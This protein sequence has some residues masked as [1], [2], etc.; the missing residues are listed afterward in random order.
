MVQK[1]RLPAVQSSSDMP[2]L[3][4]FVHLHRDL[5]HQVSGIQFLATEFFRIT[6]EPAN[7]P[8]GN[9]SETFGLIYV[10]I[11]S[12]SYFALQ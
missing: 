6:W 3:S 7:S 2:A 1:V 4:A 12:D 10:S 8:I 9:P 5:D 11:Q